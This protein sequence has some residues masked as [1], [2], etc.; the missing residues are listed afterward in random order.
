M[1]IGA[2][3]TDFACTDGPLCAGDQVEC[4]YSTNSNV[5]DWNISEKMTIIEIWIPLPIL[6]T[7]TKDLI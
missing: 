1:C 7:L 2:V 5:L 6:S 3:I 4:T